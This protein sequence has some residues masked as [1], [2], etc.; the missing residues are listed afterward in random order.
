MYNLA[1]LSPDDFERL[2]NDLLAVQL[3]T[4]IENFKSGKDKGIDGR[5]IDDNGQ[6]TII[7]SKHFIK[8]K[9][10]NLKSTIKNSELPKIKKIN[11]AKYYIA[12]SLELSDTEKNELLAVATPFIKNTSFIYGANDM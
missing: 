12:T 6:T 3:R 5:Y 8:S 7:Q 10:S 9:F 4:H 1:L 2:V 11:P